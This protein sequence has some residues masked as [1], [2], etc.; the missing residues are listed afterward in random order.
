[1]DDAAAVYLEGFLYN[2]LARMLTTCGYPRHVNDCE[3][4][5]WAI[6]PK[7]LASWVVHEVGTEISR[8]QEGKKKKGFKTEFPVDKI[9]ARLHKE[10]FEKGKNI[11]L[12]IDVVLYIMAVL[13][14]V[15]ADVLKLTGDYVIQHQQSGCYIMQ[16]DV[17][18]ATRADRGLLELFDELSEIQSLPFDSNIEAS[19]IDIDID[20]DMLTAGA[21]FLETLDIIVNVFLNIFETPPLCRIVGEPL[22]GTVF[23]YIKDL[24]DFSVIFYSKVRDCIE[25][26]GSTGIYSI[27][28]CFE[29]CYEVLK[30]CPRY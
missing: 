9:Y 10:V 6:F 29:K 5:V 30:I 13:D 8:Y 27:A 15:S 7:P 24:Q 12:K 1:M 2:L 17:Y 22:I 25:E 26:G 4:F 28:S 14:A 20:S 11:K 16:L 21:L 19:G 23:N 3:A 18:A